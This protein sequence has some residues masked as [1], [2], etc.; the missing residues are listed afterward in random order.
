MNASSTKCNQIF[1]DYKA[2]TYEACIKRI[3]KAYVAG[4]GFGS[5]QLSMFLTYALLFW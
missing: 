4:V 5:A 3:S 1:E 2:C